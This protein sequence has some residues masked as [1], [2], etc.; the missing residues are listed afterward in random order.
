MNPQE[1]IRLLEQR[2][3]LLESR[4]NRTHRPDRYLFDRPVRFGK[5]IEL[6]SEN[7]VQIGTAATQKLSFFGADPVVQF[8][9]SFNAPAGGTYGGTEQNILNGL[10]DALLSYGLIHD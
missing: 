8:A 3:A 4:V 2:I 10:Q 5:N 7:G 9:Y 1:Q 6:D